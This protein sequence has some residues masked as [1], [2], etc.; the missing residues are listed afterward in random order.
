MTFSFLITDTAIRSVNAVL[1]PDGTQTHA[2][3]HKRLG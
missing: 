3:R 2:K 1:P